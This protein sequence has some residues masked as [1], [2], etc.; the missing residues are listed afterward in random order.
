[1]PSFNIVLACVA[2]A[3]ARCLDFSTIK[4]A[5]EPWLPSTDS[6]STHTI[7]AR[8]PCD[9]LPSGSGPVALIDTPAMF[10]SNT[11]VH[12]PAQIATTPTLYTRQFVDQSASVNAA[13]YLGYVLLA[14]YDTA[15]CSAQ[16]NA[17]TG[18]NAFNI[19][20]ERDPLQEPGAA[21]INPASTTNIKCAFWSGGSS[22][23]N[24][25]NNVNNGQFR[26]SF[27]VLIAGSNGYTRIGS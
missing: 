10:S 3:A 11:L 1:M 21:C 16:C 6:H 19:Y 14:S 2:V 15:N 26:F 24:T 7:Q 27:Q 25:A 9:P 12:L 4:S 13:G 23:V 8:A 20:H 5:V 17:I 22:A 18:C